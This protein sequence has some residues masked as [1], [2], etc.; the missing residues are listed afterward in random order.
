ML[1]NLLAG[2]VFLFAGPIWVA[3]ALKA[4]RPEYY[5]VHAPMI[6]RL[7]EVTIFVTMWTFS[8]HAFLKTGLSVL[9]QG[10]EEYIIR[11]G[12]CGLI[13]S[14]G[15]LFAV[16]AVV[17]CVKGWN[18]KYR[19]KRQDSSDVSDPVRRPLSAGLRVE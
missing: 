14:I 18:V 13:L 9:Q 1:G 16:A 17:L 8:S 3:C 15:C 4:S 12:V 11:D 19:F 2:V 6:A 7:R 5:I 10:T